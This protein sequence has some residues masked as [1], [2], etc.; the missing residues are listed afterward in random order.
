MPAGVG[1]S[2]KEAT[3]PPAHS[4]ELQEILSPRAFSRIGG[5]FRKSLPAWPG[6]APWL[7]TASAETAAGRRT[8]SVAARW[9]TGFVMPSKSR[10]K[11][12]SR[13]R[14][15]PLRGEH[16]N[17]TMMKIA[18]A[19]AAIF[20]ISSAGAIRAATGFV[21]SLR[22][23]YQGAMR[24]RATGPGPGRSLRQ[25]ALRRS[26]RDLPKISVQ[27]GRCS[28]KSVLVRH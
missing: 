8:S 11:G 14:P 2:L 9:K 20:L 21:E 25:G 12:A 15:A 10:P 4:R 18:F 5:D 3:S 24:Q 7:W 26:F 1:L 17:S 28:Q 19:T 23:R 22:C 13:L 6:R 27:G 16:R